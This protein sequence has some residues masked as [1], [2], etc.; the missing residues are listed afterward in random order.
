MA[1]AEGRNRR[2]RTARQHD[3]QRH[4]RGNP[5]RPSCHGPGRRQASGPSRRDTART[6]ERD[7][8]PRTARQ[9]DKSELRLLDVRTGDL[10]RRVSSDVSAGSGTTA[11][12]RAFG[13]GL[14]FAGG[15]PLIGF[16]PADGAELWATSFDTARCPP[17]V[18]GGLVHL[19]A[20]RAEPAAEP[21]ADGHGWYARLGDATLRAL[22]TP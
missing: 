3:G 2:P 1:R 15:Q 6:N 7:R 21:A 10:A 4:E 22:N 17:A 13:A 12:G 8:R 18:G 19:T 16:D 14:L 11:L 9:H 20:G 5:G